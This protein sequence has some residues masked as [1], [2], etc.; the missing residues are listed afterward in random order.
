MKLET[1][2]QTERIIRQ[3]QSYPERISELEISWNVI[4]I[5]VPTIPFPNAVIPTS[6]AVPNI[7]I[8]YNTK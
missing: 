3:A 7:K 8:K 2:E 6:V 5:L 4:E 1:V